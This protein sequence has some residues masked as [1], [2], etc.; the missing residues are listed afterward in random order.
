R[1]TARWNDGLI[2]IASEAKQSTAPQERWIASSLAL[3]AM[4][5]RARE[6][7]PSRIHVHKIP[8]Q[9]ID[10]VV[11]ALAREHAV[12]ADAGLHVMHAPIAAHAGAEILGG[13]C[14]A[15]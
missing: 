7:G 3:L 2:V 15:D 12:M 6:T 14:L 5:R 10:L 4:T 8:Q 1:G 13:E 9:R 11:P